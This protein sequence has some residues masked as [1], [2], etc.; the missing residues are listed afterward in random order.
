M[1]VLAVEILCDWDW[2]RERERERKVTENFLIKYVWAT[3]SK[4]LI[5]PS[6]TDTGLE[7]SRGYLMEHAENKPD[8]L[9]TPALV[10]KIVHHCIATRYVLKKLHVASLNPKQLKI[11]Y[12][13]HLY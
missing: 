9:L 2:E 3:T 7:I 12:F 10:I 6:E 1:L 4:N 5:W 11:F 8:E 13:K